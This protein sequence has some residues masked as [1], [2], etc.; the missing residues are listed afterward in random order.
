MAPWNRTDLKR[1]D[2]VQALEDLDMEAARVFEGMTGV[3]YE[4]TDAYK[5]GGGP[6]V[7]WANFCCCNVY[8]GQVKKL[9]R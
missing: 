7:R 1:G 9:S 4:E 2:V 3:V 5:D 6:M 8:G